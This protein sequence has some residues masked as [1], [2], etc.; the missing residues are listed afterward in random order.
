MN[1]TPEQYFQEQ[2]FATLEAS[3]KAGHEFTPAEKA[4]MQKYLGVDA[5]DLRGRKL[6]GGERHDHD[7]GFDPHHNYALG[8]QEEPMEAVLRR[9]EQLLLVGFF[10][11]DQQFTLP[12]LAVQEVIKATPAARLPSAPGFVGGVINLRG[13]VTPLIHLGDLLEVS[14][15]NKQKDDFVVICGR[16]GL[17]IGLMIEKVHTM[18][19][20]TQ[21]SIEWAVEAHL[22]ASVEYISGLLKVNDMLVSIVSI[23][24]VVE[25]ILKGYE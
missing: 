5:A 17:Q 9:E 3:I 2:D 23:D 18:Y 19:R 4:F 10:I 22:G 25:S 24:R 14:S 21:D 20:V 11:G 16:R 1:K 13:R 15:H 7:Y 12:T 8:P 6:L